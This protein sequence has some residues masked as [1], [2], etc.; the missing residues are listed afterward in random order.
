MARVG[1][2]LSQPSGYLFY[3]FATGPLSQYRLPQQTVRA[4]LLC[5]WSFPRRQGFIRGEPVGGRM[6]VL[7]SLRN[8]M[9]KSQPHIPL[10]SAWQPSSWLACHFFKPRGQQKVPR[11]GCFSSPFYS[12]PPAPPP[13][14][15]SSLPPLSPHL[16]CHVYHQPCSPWRQRQATGLKEGSR[17]F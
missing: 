5:L 17:L 14:I 7:P 2:S 6:A 13:P 10:P 12:T 15:F 1:E 4:L 8:L 3:L 16:G 11:N 9:L